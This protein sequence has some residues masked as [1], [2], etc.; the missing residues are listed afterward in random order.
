MKLANRRAPGVRFV[1]GFRVYLVP[2]S[3]TKVTRYTLFLAKILFQTHVVKK[4]RTALDT[5]RKMAGT[6]VAVPT[7]FFCKQSNRQLEPP[8][9][10]NFACRV[11]RSSALQ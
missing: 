8:L 4:R 1:L 11:F 6:C 7:I 10:L 2:V 9:P 5:S 3:G